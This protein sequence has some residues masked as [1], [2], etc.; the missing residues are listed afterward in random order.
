MLPYVTEIR[1]IDVSASMVDKYNIEARETGR[2]EIQMHAVRGDLLAPAEAPLESEDFYGFDLVIMSMALH[3][4]DNPKAMVARLVERLRP[5]GT[6]VIIDWIP[7]EQASSP[8]YSGHS[9]KHFS[10]HEADSGKA[11]DGDHKQHPVA[12]TISF[13]GFSKEQMQSMFT[14]AGCSGSDFVLAESPSQVPL[15]PTGQKQLFFAKGT[16]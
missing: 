1:G 15:D 5:G 12:H 14:E 11:S 10:D 13:D 8:G 6:V 7:S 9:H 2:S 3:H 4:V 16:K